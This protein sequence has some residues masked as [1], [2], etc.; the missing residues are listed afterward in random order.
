MKIRKISTLLA[1]AAA[2]GLTACGGSTSKS[3]QAGKSSSKKPTT[4]SSKKPA[5]SLPPQPFAS[6]DALSFVT[7]DGVAKLD[8][9][10]SSG[11]MAA[12]TKTVKLALGLSHINSVDGGEGYVMGSATPAD[13]DYK[14][15]ATLGEK[16]AWECKI[17]LS[18]ETAMAAGR[19]MIEIGVQNYV[20]YATVAQDMGNDETSGKGNG[21]S[22]VFY[23]DG[24]L[25]YLGISVGQLPPMQLTEATIVD[26]N[27][28]GQGWL[29][30]GGKANMTQ[31]QLNALEPFIEFQNVGDGWSGDWSLKQLH[32]NTENYEYKVEGENAYLYVN[33]TSLGAGF[34]NSHVNFISRVAGDLKMEVNIEDKEY[35]IGAYKYT[36]ISRLTGKTGADF[37]GNLGIVMEELPHEKYADHTFNRR[38]VTA[39]EGYDAYQTGSC[40]CGTNLVAV[41][42]ANGHITGSN[43][44]GTPEGYVKLGSNTNHIDWKINLPAGVTEATAYLV[45]IMDTW[46]GNGSKTFYSAN[47]SAKDGNFKLEVNGTAVDFTA[48]KDVTFA[49]MLGEGSN[50]TLGSTYSQEGACE[51]GTIAL[52]EGDNTIVFTRVDSYNLLIKE[53]IFVY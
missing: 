1:V 9:K 22:F 19:Y 48:K 51:V 5:T 27:S 35:T 11:N 30:V 20:D 25:D 40:R 41:N 7:E 52:A 12:D 13:A 23:K 26:R 29:K 16:G 24:S 47:G 15:E 34:W 4:S 14:Y 33:M 49:Q 28:D 42:V 46:P 37:W 17:P 2:F 31:E 45:G 50:A 36:V 44:S 32:T 21:F 10:G 3:S 8:V 18:A 39:E 38:D 53:I 43:K 6:I